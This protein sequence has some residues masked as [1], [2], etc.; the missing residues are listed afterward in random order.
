[1]ALLNYSNITNHRPDTLLKDVFYGLGEFH[2]YLSSTRNY[3]E[4]SDAICAVHWKPVKKGQD[5]NGRFLVQLLPVRASNLGDRA[6]QS[7]MDE[8]LKHVYESDENSWNIIGAASR[9]CES[10]GKTAFKSKEHAE[11][12]ANQYGRKRVYLCEHGTG[13]HLTSSEVVKSNYK[14]EYRL[15][16]LDRLP[17]SNQLMLS[18][19]P[20]VKILVIRPDTYQ[21]RC[22]LKAIKSLQS[23]PDNMHMPLL[24]LLQPNHRAVWPL[25]ESPPSN[26]EGSCS[27]TDAEILVSTSGTIERS[28]EE[29]L[30]WMVLADDDRPGNREQREFVV[31]AMQSTDFSFLEGPPGSGKTTAICELILQ[32]ALRK[33]RILLCASTHV[34]ID[35][36]LER[37][38]SERE[39]IRDL[40][41]SI[42]IGDEKSVSP[43]VL[44]W[45]LKR[46]VNTEKK[47][48]SKYLNDCSSLDLAQE[49]MK[50]LVSGNSEK[51]ENI[52]LDS[53]NLVCGTTI[54]ILQHPQI[55]KNE[56]WV[57]VGDTKQ[58]SPFVDS[59]S[60]EK[61]V[62]ECLPEQHKRD[63]CFD[64]FHAARDKSRAYRSL[65]C[66]NTDKFNS[67]C[68]KQAEANGVPCVSN[69]AGLEKLEGSAIIVG[70]SAFIRQNEKMLNHDLTVKRHESEAINIISKNKTSL[71][72]SIENADQGTWEGD[73]SWRLINTYEQRNS[74]VAS[75]GNKTLN[76]LVEEIKCLLPHENSSEHSLVKQKLD[77]LRNVAMP[78]IME[79][80]R[81]GYNAESRNETAL[82]CGLP[83]D[84]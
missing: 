35:N 68:Q 11:E 77:L 38:Q 49:Q 21:I 75:D 48:I 13:W 25:V 6:I 1:M 15:E 2:K 62:A 42:R 24:R 64:V 7:F 16:I 4:S 71:V 34:A 22:Q 18:R 65:M 73:I 81:Y 56:R 58:L 61:S 41:M 40:L 39:E 20:Q 79:S 44:P 67:F 27:D 51:F 17:E 72:A 59:K 3:L 23:S 80:L 43:K 63:I 70:N 5:K 46:Y 69:V 36:V 83:K 45:Q 52:I 32:M 28:V 82:S 66:T 57:I 84:N 60:L 74:K 12:T 78:S 10:C 50:T 53:A 76:R 8:S 54:G 14:I 19:M 37:L 29:S 47:R 31:K 26:D 55:K 9:F 33:K 30:D